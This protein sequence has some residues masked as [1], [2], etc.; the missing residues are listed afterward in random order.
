M[1]LRDRERENRIHFVTSR[2]QNLDRPPTELLKA[3]TN[4]VGGGAAVCKP[5]K[6]LGRGQGLG[7]C[8]GELDVQG[9]EFAVYDVGL[10]V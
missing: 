10:R 2:S 7:V 4:S 5:Q 1:T 8:V 9:S 6:P 3:M